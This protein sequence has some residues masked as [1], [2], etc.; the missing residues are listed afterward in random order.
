MAKVNRIV[1]EINAVEVSLTPDQA[2][3]LRDE[4]IALF[5]E[6]CSPIVIRERVY[7]DRQIPYYPYQP[8]WVTTSTDTTNTITMKAT[9]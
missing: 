9:S 6:K 7:P 4:L 5:G 3:S 8:F 2:A 1:I